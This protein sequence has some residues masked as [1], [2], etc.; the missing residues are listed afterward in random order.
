MFSDFIVVQAEKLLKLLN[1]PTQG[2]FDWE[3]QRAAVELVELKTLSTMGTCIYQVLCA[4]DIYVKSSSAK[5][6]F[7]KAIKYIVLSFDDKF[8]NL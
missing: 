2:D 6:M 7:S 5:E 4:F 1:D 8:H 3:F